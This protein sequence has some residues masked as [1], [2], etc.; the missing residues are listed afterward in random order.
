M[1]TYAKRE[2]QVELVW[3][4]PEGSTTK[5]LYN[6]V[7]EGH[8]GGIFQV[9]GGNLP[10]NNVPQTHV[11][12]DSFYEAQITTDNLYPGRAFYLDIEEHPYNTVKFKAELLDDRGNIVTNYPVNQTVNL[13]LKITVLG[14]PSPSQGIRATFNF[15]ARG[16]DNLLYTMYKINFAGPL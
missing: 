4:S 2:R 1:N 12:G 8:P 11:N 13:R 7:L 10:G 3:T 5:S 9:K 6:I 15:V 14:Y 16:V